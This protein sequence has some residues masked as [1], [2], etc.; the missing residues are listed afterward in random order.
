MRLEYDVKTVKAGDATLK[1][2][3]APTLDTAGKGG[4]RIAAAVD[5]RPAETLSFDLKPDKPDWNAAVSNNIHIVSLPV[6]GLSAGR[7]TIKVYRIDGNVVLERV[8]L[9]TGA[10]TPTYLGPPESATGK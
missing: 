2:Y 10:V 7:H 4:L 6:K 5:D 8:V 3:L 1:L 9:E